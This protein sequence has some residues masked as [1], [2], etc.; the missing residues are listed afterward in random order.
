MPRFDSLFSEA[1]RVTTMP[2]LMEMSSA[3][4]WDTS[5]LPMVRMEY[6]CTAS[7]MG[8]P[9]MAMP[10]TSP[11]MMLMRVMMMPAMA[12]PLTNFMA[13]SMAP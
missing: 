12:S 5:P 11:P 2:A 8:M 7:I 13:P 10:M 4:I 9:F 3:G 6:V 1:T